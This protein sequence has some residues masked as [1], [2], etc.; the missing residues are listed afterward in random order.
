MKDALRQ[1]H[2]TSFRSLPGLAAH[3]VRARS[4]Y[5]AD[6]SLNGGTGLVVQ[7]NNLAGSCHGPKG[8]LQR[9]RLQ[10][11]TPCPYRWTDVT[12]LGPA[13]ATAVV[14]KF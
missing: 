10:K 3:H 2:I 12:H 6:V 14:T 7:T 4:P 9:A 8:P 1:V 5:V 13:P 11:S